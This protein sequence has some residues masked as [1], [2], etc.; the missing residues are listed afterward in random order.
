MRGIDRK[1]GFMIV[2]RPDQYVAHILPLGDFGEL[3]AFFEG[4]LQPKNER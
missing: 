3:S 2:V 1:N 4:V